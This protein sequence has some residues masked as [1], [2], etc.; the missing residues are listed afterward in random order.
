MTVYAVRDGDRWRLANALPR[1][2][3]E[4]SRDIVGPITYVY[5]PRYPFDRAR[6]RRAVAFADSVASVFGVPRLVPITYYLARSVDEV[7]A[8]MGL[9]SDVKLGPVGGAAQPVNRQ[10]FSGIPAIGEEY[11]HELAHL[12]LAPL[13]SAKTLYFVSEGVATWLGGTTGKDYPTAVR[14]LAAFLAQRPAVSLDSLLG[15]SFPA[16]Q[17]YPAAAVLVAMVFDEG[18]VAAVREL[19]DAGASPADLRATVQRQL[20]RPWSTIV[21]DWHRFVM[22]FVQ[23]RERQR[24]TSTIR[25]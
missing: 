14:D 24:D 21:E 13:S 1:H 15:G 6:A 11:R 18:G 23:L 12:V 4:W 25:P 5:P 17:L 19:F 7:Y 16:A 10:L 2:T 22:T 20:A 8:I 9:E 3:R